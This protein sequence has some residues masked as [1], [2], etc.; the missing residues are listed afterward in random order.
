MQ[1]QNEW[2]IR[3]EI[4]HRLNVNHTDDLKSVKIQEVPEGQVLDYAIEYFTNELGVKC[5]L[6]CIFA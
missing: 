4:Y 5:I 6:R 2:K 1:K 3:Q